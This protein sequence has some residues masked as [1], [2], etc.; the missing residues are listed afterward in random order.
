MVNGEKDTAT[1]CESYLRGRQDALREVKQAI[2]GIAMDLNAEIA[3]LPDATI[4]PFTEQR[5]QEQRMLQAGIDAKVD[6]LG[7]V[8]EAIADIVENPPNCP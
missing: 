5:N 4:E 8:S 1:G 7:I 6:T 3:N 2:G